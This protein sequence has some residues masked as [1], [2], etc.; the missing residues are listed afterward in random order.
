MLTKDHEAGRL[1]KH[2]EIEA[3]QIPGDEVYRA[4]NSQ[5]GRRLGKDSRLPG[6][7][8]RLLVVTTSY[9]LDSQSASAYH[10]KGYLEGLAG[11]FRITIITPDSDRDF[12]PDFTGDA[13]GRIV[14]LRYAPRKWQV[15]ANRPG[16][17]PWRLPAGRWCYCWPPCFG[18][19]CFFPWPG[20]P[21]RR[22]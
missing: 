8:P 4:N 18:G 1:G 13:A 16:G 5:K 20:M 15:L 3:P 11:R 14:R 6:K 19:Q 17:C 10:I 22:T 2:F 9:P 12:W 7:P 21:G